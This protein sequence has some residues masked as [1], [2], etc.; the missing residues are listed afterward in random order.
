[1]R[2]TR[3]TPH[4]RHVF[5]PASSLSLSLLQAEPSISF[6]PSH[7]CGLA[8]SFLPFYNSTDLFH[9]GAMCGKNAAVGSSLGEAQ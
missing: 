6:Q 4:A 3:V 2:L 8:S 5:A 1:M 9:A 7:M